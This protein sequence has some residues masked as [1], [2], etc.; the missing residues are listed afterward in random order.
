MKTTTARTTRPPIKSSVEPTPPSPEKKIES[1]IT[2]P[3]SA[4]VPAATIS[5]PKVEEI[6][7]ASFSTGIRT[8]SEVA[9]RMIAIS[10]GV[11]ISPVA[12]ST[13]ATSNAIPKDT[14]NAISVTRR[15]CPRSRWKSISSPAR[16]SRK[17]SPSTEITEI[18]SSTW[19]IPST[20]GPITIPARISSTTDGS[21]TLGKKP[22]VSGATKVTATTISRLSKAGIAGSADQRHCRVVS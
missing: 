12:F 15:T 6:S 3:K 17:A 16:K 4:I 1:R 5:W 14:T 18:A 2:A 20:E 21:F 11:S 19:T 10:S 13:S 7:P 22:R 9:Q 8:P